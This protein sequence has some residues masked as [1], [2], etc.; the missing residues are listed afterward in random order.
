MDDEALR[1]PD[2][3]ESFKREVRAHAKL[4]HPAVARVFDHGRIPD[5][6]ASSSDGR[7]TKGAPYLVIEF[8]EAGTLLDTLPLRSWDE[9]ISALLS[10]LDGLAHA[11]AR[12]VLHR[13]LKPENILRFPEADTPAQWR[14]TDFGI[15]QATEQV[16]ERSTDQLDGISAGTTHFM[17]P[18]QLRGQWRRAGPWTDLYQVGCIAYELACGQPP[19]DGQSAMDIASAHLNEPIPSL[20]NQIPVPGSFEEWINALMQKDPANRPV[21]ACQAASSLEDM[22]KSVDSR[23]DLTNSSAIQSQTTKVDL[24]STRTLKHL[25]ENDRDSEET[26]QF[27]RTTQVT[28][29]EASSKSNNLTLT[30]V[31]I[32]DSRPSQKN[33]KAEIELYDVGLGLFGLR[34]PSFIDRRRERDILWTQLQHVAE[35]PETR[36]VSIEGKAGTGKSRLAKWLV[37]RAH[38]IGSA[39]TITAEADNQNRRSGLTGV[40]DDWF[41]TWELDRQSA[42]RVIEDRMRFYTSAD[43]VKGSRLRDDASA[44]GR[45][46]RPEPDE[47]TNQGWSIET[48]PS[49]DAKQVIG[50]V[51]ERLGLSQPLIVW[52]DDLQRTEAG[53]RFIDWVLA[54]PEPLPILIVCTVQTDDPNSIEDVK[55]RI[56]EM[57]PASQF[58]QLP[59]GKLD[60]S[61]HLEFIERLL[62]VESELASDLHARTEGMPLFTQELMRHWV[63][64]NRLE[65][66]PDG[67]ELSDHSTSDI[68][69]GIHQLWMSR[70]RAVVHSTNTVSDEKI[71]ETLE[72]AAV[73]G[74][75]IN[76]TEFEW[77]TQ[78]A[79]WSNGKK[80]L[81]ALIEEG[82]ADHTKN[83]WRLAHNLLVE[84]LT[85]RA[86]QNDR[87]ESLNLFAAQNLREIYSEN[88]KQIERRRADHLIECRRYEEAFDALYAAATYHLS[89]TTLKDEYS[90]DAMLQLQ[91]R[92]LDKLQ[93]D[94]NDRRRLKHMYLTAEV[95]LISEDYTGCMSAA[96]RLRDL[97]KRSSRDYFL[98][99]SHY[100]RGAV[101]FFQGKFENA[102]Q[103]FQKAQNF[104]KKAES[105]PH[106]QVELYLGYLLAHEGKFESANRHLSRAEE[107]AEQH[108]K[109]GASDKDAYNLAE[110]RRIRAYNSLKQHR[111]ADAKTLLKEALEIT[112]NHDLVESKAHIFETLGEVYRSQEN[113][114]QAIDCYEKNSIWQ[115]NFWKSVRM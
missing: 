23:S 64:E 76:R 59:L 15:A 37:R 7:L 115:K 110:A 35:A 98:G 106:Y 79:K 51:L 17:S 32:E 72:L 83:G 100:L 70:L 44:L 114:E 14:L 103:E 65:P 48:A 109:S 53:L 82:L 1:S 105:G 19:F 45:M 68:P 28:S 90:I 12:G 34:E 111:L 108:Y 99:Q 18:E 40:M 112:Q 57:V 81:D 102:R 69:T 55:S 96:N 52:I 43:E 56:S 66:G 26:R 8:A 50:R 92:L 73:L 41:Q 10:I 87:Y 97:A 11:H 61:D 3:I 58:Y 104:L 38:E 21:R 16:R 107:Y 22:N 85:K 42:S 88:P 67:F 80:I 47:G 36:V 29:D 62:P 6:T 33:F 54:Y 71:W 60:E 49:P 86:K 94:K 113:F 25:R 75:R 31:G 2:A 63:Q 78:T 24:T 101:Q 77:M 39:I 30:S 27:P 84:T 95:R 20:S 74:R 13:D 4:N 93:V 5:K 46:L 91:A 89:R 9:L